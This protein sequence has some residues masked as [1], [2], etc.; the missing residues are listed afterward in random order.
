MHAGT[1][2]APLLVSTAGLTFAVRGTSD[3]ERRGASGILTTVPSSSDPHMDE[4]DTVLANISWVRTAWYPPWLL[5]HDCAAR[6]KGATPT[7][8]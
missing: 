5:M 4:E 8:P 6:A 7:Y 2:R 3:G 1:P